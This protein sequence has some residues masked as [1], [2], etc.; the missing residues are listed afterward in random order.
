MCCSG[1][2]ICNMSS[3]GVFLSSEHPHE[4]LWVVHAK[5]LKDMNITVQKVGSGKIMSRIPKG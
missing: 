2:D 3:L 1:F 5:I 4:L